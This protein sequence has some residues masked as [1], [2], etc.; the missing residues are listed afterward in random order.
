[1]VNALAKPTR[2][3]TGNV[4]LS[5]AHIWEP[6]SVNGSDPKYSVSI[7]IPK[8]DT[9]T[10]TA[11]QNAI[12]AAKEE[13]KTKFGARFLPVNKIPLHDGDIERPSDEAYKNAYFVNC[14]SKERPQIVDEKLNTILNHEE[15]Y[16]GCYARVSIGFYP[17]SVNVNKGIAAG[18]G[19]IQK[20]ADGEPL[21]SRPSADE[22]FIIPYDDI[23]PND[24]PF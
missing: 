16:S 15:V 6:K 2:V 9:R 14:N 4:R 11:I 18:L 7:I 12:E 21:S 17:F 3:V 13:G 20:I 23:N 10:V 22:D 19:H 1:M 24:Q 8:S 5:Y